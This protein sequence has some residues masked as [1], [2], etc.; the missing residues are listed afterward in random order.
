MTST[1]HIETTCVAEINSIIEN[2]FKALNTIKDNKLEKK[3]EEYIAL[4]N[5]RN[6]KK[7]TCK[8]IAKNIITHST[9]P[10]I[11]T[12]IIFVESSYNKRAVNKHSGATGLG[13]IHPIHKKELKDAGII[14]SFNEL[15]KVEP[16][17]KAI[18]FVLQKKLKITGGDMNEALKLYS[19]NSTDYNE[20]ISNKV[21][22]INKYIKTS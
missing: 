16:N 19:G 20:T 2:N 18:E 11:T 1:K 5:K 3:I 10:V 17:V 22:E 7:E 15:T 6:L 21:N 13:Q 12:S 9:F 4:D 14:T 8:S